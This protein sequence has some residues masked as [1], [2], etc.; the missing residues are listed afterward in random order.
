M[1]IPF[2]DMREYTHEEMPI[3]ILEVLSEKYGFEAKGI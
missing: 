2:I 1:N 3:R